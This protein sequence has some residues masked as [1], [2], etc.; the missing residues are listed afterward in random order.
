[1]VSQLIEVSKKIVSQQIQLSEDLKKAADDNGVFTKQFFSSMSDI[2][3][4]L[5]SLCAKDRMIGLESGARDSH[6]PFIERLVIIG[7]CFVKLQTLLGMIPFSDS[8]SLYDVSTDLKV[9]AIRNA[10]KFVISA[11]KEDSLLTF[12]KAH[13]STSAGGKTSR[14]L[15]SLN[16]LEVK[17][18]PMKLYRGCGS[19]FSSQM[20][21]PMSVRSDSMTTNE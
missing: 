15:S 11:N 1:M 17:V 7:F 12:L 16:F 20:S 2:E 4:N 10:A 3:A 8:A 18:E 21:R 5:S 14:F 19:L 6:S 13:I 9:S